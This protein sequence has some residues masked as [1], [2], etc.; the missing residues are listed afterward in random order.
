[1]KHD[2][3]IKIFIEAMAQVYSEVELRESL[4]LRSDLSGF[5]NVT[6]SVVKILIEG[7]L[8]IKVLRSGRS[9]QGIGGEVVQ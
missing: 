4:K 6:E 1:M 2:Y 5:L 8:Q 9:L 7:A 3:N